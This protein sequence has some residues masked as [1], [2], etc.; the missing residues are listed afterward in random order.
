M[1][2]EQGLGGRT[3]QLQSLRT[4]P[5][6]ELLRHIEELS[7]ELY[8]LKAGLKGDC[9]SSS[10]LRIWNESSQ[11][12]QDP[13]PSAVESYRFECYRLCAPFRSFPSNAQAPPLTCHAGCTSSNCRQSASD[14]SATEAYQVSN[15][16]SKG[17]LRHAKI[18]RRHTY[19]CTADS[20]GS[21]MDTLDM[22]STKCNPVKVLL[23]TKM[24]HVLLGCNI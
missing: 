23:S 20:A 14:T 3:L 16:S 2:C 9:E 22:Y 5:L 15:S 18:T 17:S 11:R 13:R 8:R 12:A 10:S 24:Q 7:R 21:T 1:L 6:Q 4:L 19:I